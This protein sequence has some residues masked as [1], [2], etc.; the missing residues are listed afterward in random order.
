MLTLVVFSTFDA[1]AVEG[2]KWFS[3]VQP[4]RAVAVAACPGP[5]PW[6]PPNTRPAIAGAIEDHLEWLVVDVCRTKDDVL[7]LFKNAKDLA[8]STNGKGAV[9]DTTAAELRR[10]DAGAAFAT[11]FQGERI[12]TLEEC[13]SLCK[14]KINL[15]LDCRGVEPV[16]L[17]KQ[18]TSADMENQVVVFDGLE[19]LRKVR[20]ASEG[21]VP[22]MS[23]W[24]PS[25]KDEVWM[26]IA[27]FVAKERPAMVQ[28]DVQDLTA[29]ICQR[30]QSFGV[31][32]LGRAAGDKDQEEYWDK[33]V[34]RGVNVLQTGLPE[35]VLAQQVVRRVPRRPV[36]FCL[37][38][39]ASRY[40]P[41]NTI[42]AVEKS[43]RLAADYVELDI[44]TSGDG[45]L[46]ILH[47]ATVDRTTDGQGPIARMSSDAIGNLDAGIRFGEP[48]RGMRVPRFEE[49]MKA[50]DGKIQ[51]YADAKNLAA[52]DL[53]RV[54]QKYDYVDRTVIYQGPA[55]LAEVK[56]LEPRAK[57][58]PPLVTSAAVDVLAKTLRPYAV[59]AS[60]NILSKKL[61]DR[62]HAHGMRVFSD[63]PDEDLGLEPYQRVIE[64]GI[65]LIQTD[66]PL[67]VLRAIEVLGHKEAK[68]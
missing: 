23:R 18:I 14:D 65:D 19:N 37:H 45:E 46:F 2:W 44:R 48:F 67:D 13:F 61:I 54:L 60:W 34:S 57:V 33:A 21:R 6:A 58:M 4:P 11:R 26:D 17:A 49:C 39:G 7:V 64:W 12:L 31:L 22:V 63:A 47:D 25:G 9:R 40:V 10:L 42:A 5:K 35:E 1:L 24:R 27:K 20:E 8:L 53:V 66:R 43:L 28:I 55:F 29:E 36:R 30:F 41:E 15:V 56:R 50:M 52:A 68:P 59:D 32:V 38:R 51:F 3:P 62:C 16:A